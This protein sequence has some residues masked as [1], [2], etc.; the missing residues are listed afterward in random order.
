MVLVPLESFQLR[1][2][3][4]QI[5]APANCWTLARTSRTL[6]ESDRNAARF[7]HTLLGDRWPVAT[8]EMVFFTDSV[9]KGCPPVRKMQLD[10]GRLT[11][12]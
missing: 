9:R 11:T 10:E 8:C 3:E 4:S 6:G 5:E 2:A 7:T 12:G 1:A